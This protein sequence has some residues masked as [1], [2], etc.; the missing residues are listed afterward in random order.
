[1]KPGT[2]VAR[3]GITVI[4]MIL[5]SAV[6]RRGPARTGTLRV[7]VRDAKTLFAHP[8]GRPDSKLSAA[9]AS[10]LAR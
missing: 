9:P 7:A 10:V 1:M 2:V 5:P 8:L 6:W 4:F 3:I